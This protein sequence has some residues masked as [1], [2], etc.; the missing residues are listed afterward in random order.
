M[1]MQFISQ[2]IIEGPNI[3]T[4]EINGAIRLLEDQ[5]D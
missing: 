1:P 2:K 3:H 5:V 4:L